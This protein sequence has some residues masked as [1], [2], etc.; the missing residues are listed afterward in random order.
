[1]LAVLLVA[2]ATLFLAREPVLGWL[3][4]Q[5]VR[6]DQLVR[7]DAI[8]VL[9]GGTPQREIEAADLYTAGWAPKVLMT[10]DDETPAY[11]VLRKRGIHLETQNQLKKRILLSLGVPE[12]AVTILDDRIANS[13]ITETELV[14]SWLVSNPAKRL[15]IVTSP[16]HTARA[17]LIFIRSLRD[18]GIEI[19]THPASHERFDARNWWR[20]RE[21]LRN[22]I[23]EWQKLMAY[24][25]LYR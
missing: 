7:A 21:Q 17:R 12:S 2:A 16:Y 3:G 6:S 9:A 13:T 5:L 15:I 4:A 10:K 11:D 23:V 24:S 8:V 18:T 22:G 19:L 25:V 1:M 14:R 20:D